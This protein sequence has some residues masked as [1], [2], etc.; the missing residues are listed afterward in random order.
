MACASI[1][2]CQFDED[3]YDE[4]NDDDLQQDGDVPRLSYVLPCEHAAWLTWGSGTNL[5][6]LCQS[7]PALAR[8]ERDVVK[9]YRHGVGLDRSAFGTYERILAYDVMQTVG[10]RI[11][12]VLRLA[13]SL[14][15]ELTSGICVVCVGG[16]A[17]AVYV[18]LARMFP[19][20]WFTCYETSD[21]Q[22]NAAKKRLKKMV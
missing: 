6:L 3:G 9:C 10:V 19:R 17:D 15:D 14:M 1:V 21:R 8:V 16:A 12:S 2:E 11:V 7:I 18:R 13:P 5:G 20:S 22:A 4:D